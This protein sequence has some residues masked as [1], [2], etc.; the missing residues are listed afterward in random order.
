MINLYQTIVVENPA[1]LAGWPTLLILTGCLNHKPD[2]HRWNFPT[3]AFQFANCTSRKSESNIIEPSL[4]L[5]KNLDPATAQHPSKGLSWFF[6]G[7]ST[8]YGRKLGLNDALSKTTRSSL[9]PRPWEKLPGEAD[10]GSL[11][12]AASERVWNKLWWL[13]LEEKLWKMCFL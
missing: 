7:F 12:G 10:F 13:F 2:Y 3:F 8:F 1:R 9:R 4:G 11:Q 5:S 6:H